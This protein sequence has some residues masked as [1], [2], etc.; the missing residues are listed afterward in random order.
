MDLNKKHLLYLIIFP[1]FW[2]LNAFGQSINISGRIL[3]QNTQEPVEYA[4]IVL[5]KQDSIFLKGTV[6]DSIG[7]F[8]FINLSPNDY[9]LSA[10]C[11]GFEPKKIL[12]Q[13]LSESVEINVF[14]NE[15]ILSLGEVI[16]SA[17]STISK[18]NQRIVFPTKLQLSHSANGM[19]LLNTMML[20]GLNINPMSNTISSSDGGKVVLQI[21]GVNATSEEI[22]T[23]QPR[24]IRRVE[25]LDYAGVR[26][27][28]AS[29]IVNYVVTRDD[30]GG[31]IGVD[32][33]N[34]LNILAGG[35][36]FFAK[37]NKGK[38]EYALNYTTA[39]QKINSNNRTRTGS[40][41]FENS[42]ILQRDE[43]GEGG[44]Y[45]Y[46]MHDV[47]FLYNYQQGDSTFFNAK[48]K[49]AL[50]NHPH[51][52]FKSSLNKNSVNVGRIF[53]G[54]SQKINTP[55]VDLYYERGL[56]NRQKIYAN[57][58]GSYAKAETHRNYIEYDNIDTLFKEQF[59]LV[60]DKY[61][62]IAEGIYE[63]SFTHGSLKL[64]V[65]HIQSF[66]QQK[67][68]QNGTFESDLY[69]AESSVFT[70]WNHSKD[71]LSYS[72][73][74][75]ANRVH[76]SNTSINKSYYNLLPKVMFGYRLN[77]KSFIR[78]DVEMSQTNPT[79]VELIDTEIILD[80]YLVEKG[81]LSLKPYSNL[82]NNLFYENRKGL[83]TFNANLRCHYKHNPIMESIK[84]QGDLFLV[85]PENMKSWSRYNAE[86]T[87]KVGMIKNILQ[88]SLTGGYNHSN[89]QGNNYSHTHS[90]FYY[91]ANVLAMY[92]KWMFIGQIQ[93]FN[94]ILYGETVIKDGNYHY[95]A[96]QY[97]ANNF[98]FG[99]GAFNPFRNSSRSIME[100][101]NIQAP[102]RRESFSNASQTIVATL[103]WNFSF[104]KIHNSSSK[105]IDNQD[106]DYGVKSSYK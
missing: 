30:K 26:Y 66:T 99:I 75:R 21:N 34:S 91:S 28:E 44:D 1:L 89:S 103:T 86:M 20:P 49:Y 88:F 35:D 29:K 82:N 62:L 43:I 70:E 63:K 15:S 101:K 50:T 68:W 106:S 16:I 22:L 38:S 52:D 79:L 72:L 42:P 78:Y 24:Q 54:V 100:N 10:S 40:Y 104:G 67:V 83:F 3:N 51:N 12:L 18:I 95:L 81:N 31:V 60:S 94:E 56:K 14:L 55:T 58:V 61:S 92:N 84:Q 69:Q 17:S 87:L 96:I 19:Q 98:S 5:S 23:L 76:F 59:G 4:S 41:L 80:P 33:M 7:R 36:V 2:N 48:L 90:N 37:F 77:E 93:P 27:G 13:N 11:M 53:D 73:G 8:E 57:F 65:K 47:S 71:N 32:L 85:M 97:N 64:G 102:F 25:Y 39:F 45:S 6:S 105:Y 9:V 46:Q 74:L